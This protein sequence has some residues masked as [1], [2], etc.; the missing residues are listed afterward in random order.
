[1]IKR[2]SKTKTKK[3]SYTLNATNSTVCTSSK[4]NISKRMRKQAKVR[5]ALVAL[6]NLAKDIHKH[7]KK[8]LVQATANFLA[9]YAHLFSLDGDQ[10]NEIHPLAF[11]TRELGHN[12][13]I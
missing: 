5:S 8:K 6:R 9:H 3:I 13:N 10:M 7:D 4:Q 2:K 12:P 1:M 11:A